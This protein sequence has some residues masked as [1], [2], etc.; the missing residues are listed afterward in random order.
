MPRKNTIPGKI[1]GEISMLRISKYDQHT[2]T[3]QRNL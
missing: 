2:V 1:E 3:E